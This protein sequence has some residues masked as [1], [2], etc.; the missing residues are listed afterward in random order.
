[1]LIFDLCLHISNHLTAL[2]H[3]S[4]KLE[5]VEGNVKHKYKEVLEQTHADNVKVRRRVF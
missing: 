4:S 2:S 1:M 5:A 3:R